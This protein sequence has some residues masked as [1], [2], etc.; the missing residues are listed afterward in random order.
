MSEAGARPGAFAAAGP[1]IVRG[2]RVST[3]GR[4]ALAAALLACGPGVCSAESLSDAIRLAYETNPALRAKQAQLRAIDEGYV[5]A[6]AGYGPQ[7]SLT[8]QA[9]HV[10]AA[11]QQPAS[12]FSPA[13][14][15][16]LHADTGSADLSLTQ[17][18]Y[19]AGQ[20]RA[21]VRG[22]SAS[23]LAG[24]ESLRQAESQLLQNVITAY[25]D[26]RRDRESVQII[27]DEIVALKG[28][29]D[30]TK[31]K[32]ALGALSKTDVAQSEARLLSAEAQLNLAQGRLNAS[33]AEYLN[34]VG[35]SP[36]ELEPEPELAGVPDTVDQAFEAADHNNAE[37]LAA[38]E[39]ERVARENVNQAKAAFG[40][41]VSVRLDAAITPNA[42]Y[43]P[44]Q[45]DR[46][47]TAAVVFSQPLF[48]SGLN[49]SRVRE[50]LERDNS[51]LLEIEATRRGLVQLVAQ[52]WDQLVSTQSAIAI[53]DRQVD[54]E[55]VAVEGNRIEERVGLRSTIDMLN[56]ELELANTRLA[57]VQSRHDEY[58]AGA[59]L[60]SAMGLL[61]ARFLTPGVQAY[62]PEASFDRVKTLGAAPW[63][64][65]VEVVDGIGAPNSPAPRV[66]SPE[67]GADRPADMP[68]LPKPAP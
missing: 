16:A 24:R 40:P 19:T 2:R 36:G 56:A 50:A 4:L 61:E 18:L 55:K 64:S 23:V 22:A 15:S 58:V 37:L 12:F 38:I 53:E 13:T 44:E 30:E 28:E 25:V 59:A 26:V 9:A 62:S 7:V 31:A 29:F 54:V 51:A 68:S 48:T 33:S 66:S 45:Y 67:A 47:I 14:T 52:A 42:P 17:P 34:A 27:K 65:A 5:Q 6:R 43:L 63:E 1:A 10:D 8:G 3:I 11:V 46:S 60:L 21:R 32:G 41:T 49:S 35:Q 39:N 57:L 20:T